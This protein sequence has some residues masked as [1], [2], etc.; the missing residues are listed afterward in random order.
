[1][2]IANEVITETLV[3]PS[4]VLRML[5]HRMFFISRLP[6]PWVKRPSL[7]TIEV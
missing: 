4:V 3:Q 2:K 7:V 6:S 5:V 1:M